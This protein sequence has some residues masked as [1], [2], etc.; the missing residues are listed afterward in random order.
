MVCGLGGWADCKRSRTND[1]NTS[2]NDDDDDNKSHH[3]ND[4][5]MTP[6]ASFC[7]RLCAY[8]CERRVFFEYN[9]TTTKAA[10]H[11]C[12]TKKGFPSPWDVILF[13]I[14]SQED[15]FNSVGIF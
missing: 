1:D 7:V 3:D 2:R 5:I 9:I 15:W 4:H 8:F 14:R 11:L 12:V 6:V 10:L 13:W